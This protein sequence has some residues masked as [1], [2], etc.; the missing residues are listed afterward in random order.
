MS[1]ASLNSNAQSSGFCDA[2]D[3]AY[4]YLCSK[5]PGDESAW[6]NKMA[7]RVVK[8]AAETNDDISRV[9]SMQF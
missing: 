1:Y 7:A 5:Y 6:L 8:I 3:Q 2:E 4:H 9:V